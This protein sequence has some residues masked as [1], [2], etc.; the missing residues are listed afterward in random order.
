[1]RRRRNKSC[2]RVLIWASAS[3]G[4][5]L[6]CKSGDAMELLRKLCASKTYALQSTVNPPDLSG[7]QLSNFSGCFLKYTAKSLPL[8]N[9]NRL[10]STIPFLQ[11][12][13][14]LLLRLSVSTF[15]PSVCCST[16]ARV[17]FL[18]VF[19]SNSK[20][21]EFVLKL[22]YLGHA[23]TSGYDLTQYV[24][25]WWQNSR[26]RVESW[27]VTQARSKDLRKVRTTSCCTS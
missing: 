2:M 7:I 11:S 15:R 17:F 20:T 5:Y 6:C 13:P 14:C 27:C 3:P 23:S 24:E 22:L 25:R 8:K 12:R 26:K 16:Q 18:T 9:S 19:S 4:R 21:S 10:S 1:M